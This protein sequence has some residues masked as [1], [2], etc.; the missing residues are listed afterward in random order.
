MVFLLL[1]L[2]VKVVFEKCLLLWLSI[3]TAALWFSLLAMLYS[4][5]P[6]YHC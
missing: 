4:Q 5:K 3:F 6:I 2:V 1:E